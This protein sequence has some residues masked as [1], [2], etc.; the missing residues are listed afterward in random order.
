MVCKRILW[1]GLFVFNLQG[2]TFGQVIYKDTIVVLLKQSDSLFLAKNLSLMAE[3]FNVEATRALILQSKLWDNPNITVNQNVVN[4]AYSQNGG[5]KWL[6]WTNNGETSAQ[7]QQLF[8]LAGKRNKRISLA[9]L[10]ATREE[11]NYFDMFRTLKYSLRSGFYDIYYTQQIIKVYDKEIYALDKIIKVFESQL[12]KGYASKKDVLRLK[13]SLFSL[14]SERNGFITQLFGNL[15]DFNVLMHTSGVYYLPLPD[16][17]FL[18]GFSTDSLRLAQIVDTALVSRYDLKMDQTDL[19]LNQYNL[20]YQKAMTVPDLNLI[21][22]WD[23]NGSFIHN[24]NYLGF[25]IDLPFFNRNQGNIQSAK[26]TVESSKLKL[27]GTEDQVRADVI[28]A[29]ATLI[30]DQQ[31][32]LRFDKKFAVELERLNDEVVKNYEK[33]NISL[34]EFVDFYDAYKS[35]M[36]QLN[37]L[38]N[39]RANALENLNFSTGKEIIQ[40]P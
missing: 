11:Q 27:L 12:D 24:Y 6:D 40:Y 32:F 31:L 5:R 7:I 28:Q 35:N 22:G 19:D 10:T 37:T 4:S 39:N 18:S 34:L 14:E 23:R 38:L 30:E 2:V 3:K 9:R 21:G 17:V 29:F 33:R 25:Q 16:T 8:L 36:V 1:L 13:S 15:A 26:A 20:A